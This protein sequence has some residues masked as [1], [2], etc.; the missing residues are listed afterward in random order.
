MGAVV[1]DRVGLG[2]VVPAQHL[3]ELAV[4]SGR[5]RVDE[6]QLVQSLDAALAAVEDG[7]E[8]AVPARRQGVNRRVLAAVPQPQPSHEPVSILPRT[9][10][11]QGTGPAKVLPADV[12]LVR[13]LKVKKALFRSRRRRRLSRVAPPAASGRCRVL[14]RRGDGSAT[15]AAAAAAAPRRAL[16]PRDLVT[17][18][19]ADALQHRDDLVEVARAVA[20]APAQLRAGTRTI[21]R[22]LWWAAGALEVGGRRSRQVARRQPRVYLVQLPGVFVVRMPRRRHPA[23]VVLVVLVV[24]LVILVVVAV[25]IVVVG[26]ASGA[27]RLG[28]RQR[29]VRATGCPQQQRYQVEDEQDRPGAARLESP[30]VPRPP[31][32][33]TPLEG[34]AVSSRRPLAATGRASVQGSD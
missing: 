8:G 11:S 3:L 24:V 33:R 17:G 23:V 5:E 12:P 15:A 22:H 29:Q 28:G 18:R 16:W 4:Q 1:D 2:A 9:R 13:L 26:C 30:A 20:I 34:S 25:I 27:G 21:L 7:L 32:R 19:L 31:P 14:P 6:Q 10:K